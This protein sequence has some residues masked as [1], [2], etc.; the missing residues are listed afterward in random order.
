MQLLRN[1]LLRLAFSHEPLHR[2]I[3]LQENRASAFPTPLSPRS[4]MSKQRRSSSRGCHQM[5]RLERIAISTEDSLS[6]I[7]QIPEHMEAVSDLKSFWRSLTGPKG[8]LGCS[9]ATDHLNAGMA[10]EPCSHCGRLSIGQD[11]NGRAGFKIDQQCPV[12]VPTTKRKLVNA[13]KARSGFRRTRA[14]ADD[15]QKR[16]ARA[17]ETKPSP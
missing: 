8:Q 2:F 16:H 10:L 17:L 7:A 6:D 3:A 4:A 13:K 9:I 15:S 1:L 14:S 11:V 5:N 12:R